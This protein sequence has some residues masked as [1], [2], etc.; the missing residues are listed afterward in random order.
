[1][2]LRILAVWMVLI[3]PS[4]QRSLPFVQPNDNRT[5]AGTW[6]GDTL[7]LALVVQMAV[8]HPEADAG[9]AIT[10]AAFGEEG[11]APQIP[12]PLIRV[13]AGTVIDATIR[14]ALTDST[15][16]IRGL[17]THPATA[18]DSIVV[19]PGATGHVV[20]AAG[21][22]GT[23]L[24][25]AD[26]GVQ[27]TLVEREQ[28][29]GALVVDSAGA[30]TDDRIFVMNI[31][32]DMVD[33]SR[34][35]NALTINGKS[36]PYT[37]RITL[38]VGDTARW[39]WVNATGRNHPMHLHGFYFLVQRHGTPLADTAF[40]PARQ[41]LV[42]TEELR[43]GATMTIA[44]SPTRPGNWL[45]HCHIAFHV[46]PGDAELSAGPSIM[47]DGQH[48]AGLI[49]G[50][51]VPSPPKWRAPARSRPRRVT[52]AISELPRHRDSLRTIGVAIADHD[53][54]LPPARSPGPVLVVTREQP[55]D[56]TVIN[57][58]AQTSAIHWHGIEL[59]SYSD[60]V[61]GWSGAP[62][63]LAPFIAPGDSFVAHL[64]LP[65][66]GTFIY[67]THLNDFSQLTAGLYGA[68]V[69]LEPGQRFHPATDHVFVVGWDGPADPP[70][71]A[72]NGDIDSTPGSL[73]LSAGVTH[74]LRFVNIGPAQLVRVSVLRDSTP[75]MWRPLAKDGMNLPPA[76][77]TPRAS[78]MLV[79]VG[80]TFDAAISPEPGTYVV[81]VALPT[82]RP[83]YH[84]VLRVR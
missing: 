48:M 58:L 5:P 78:G 39:R 27:D 66:A 59:E 72:V 37:E 75:V 50:I 41:R 53:A 36:W 42:V 60:G 47:H 67:H 70:R 7:H 6:R 17:Y 18:I 55:T 79:R 9:P 24:Y 22:P 8:W 69:V 13:P 16:I 12:A 38:A 56:V 15:L 65:R 62:G 20:F 23:Y 19:S 84:R 80:E 34:Y 82:G 61:A 35:G 31:W 45:F 52:L 30:R 25:D 29:G 64:T 74:R 83:V 10:V 54:A 1:M 51:V 40:I 77:T 71:I 26:A 14:N 68:I 81:T 28:L 44:W 21:A 2:N 3:G 46:L 49:L 63:R 11:G 76:Q 33:S 4:P 32:G 73:E 43:P 57:H